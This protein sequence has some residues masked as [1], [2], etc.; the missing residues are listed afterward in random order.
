MEM[1]YI[2]VKDLKK[3]SELWSKLEEEQE[4]I[5][6]KDGKPKAIMI[7][8]EPEE[9]E[10]TVREIRRLK[11]SIAVGRVRARASGDNTV[12]YDEQNE[13]GKVIAERAVEG[14]RKKTQ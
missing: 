2:Q 11:F 12:S 3:T 4:L 6:T 1:S 10:K 7:S 5:I 13:S 8:I 9:L 14:M